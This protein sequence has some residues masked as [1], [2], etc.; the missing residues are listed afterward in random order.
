[1]CALK[2]NKMQFMV[3]LSVAVSEN[4]PVKCM[5]ICVWRDRIPNSERCFV[6]SKIQMS[7]TCPEQDEDE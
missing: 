3:F 5:E 1:M 2:S 7:R 6:E 4:F